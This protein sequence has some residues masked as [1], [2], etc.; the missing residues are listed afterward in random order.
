VFAPV[1]DATKSKFPD[2]QFERMNLDDP[3]TQPFAD[4]WGRSIPR[5]VFLDSSSN[6]LFNS[7][8]PLN[9]GRFE[10][11]VQQFH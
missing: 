5:V 7:N 9:R 11:L 4:K 10:K 8:P 2:V 1:F 6:V 3:A